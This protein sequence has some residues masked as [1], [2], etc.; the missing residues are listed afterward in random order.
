[1]QLISVHSNEYV[2]EKFGIPWCRKWKFKKM[3]ITS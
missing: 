1:M 2:T 3:E